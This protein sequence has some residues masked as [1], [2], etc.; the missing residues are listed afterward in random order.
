M[1]ASWRSSSLALLLVACVPTR[2][3]T[4]H[5]LGV[6]DPSEQVPPELYRIKITGKAQ[7]MSKVKYGSGW[8]PARQADLLVQDIRPD[9]QGKFTISGQ[10][11]DAVSMAVRRRFFEI[12][13]FAVA[14]E[15]EDGRFVVVM[16]S[17]PDYFFKKI[18]L[19]T[20]FGKDD[21][22]EASS[23]AALIGKVQQKR[24]A[25]GQ[26]ALATRKELEG[27]NSADTQA[28]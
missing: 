22:A 27:T 19:L 8:V 2:V 10:N 5:F 7:W 11:S 17:D 24:I 20:R 9:E 21:S 28:K 6:F 14:T 15:P 13:P 26:D 1:L 18:G 16:S 12:G 23:R 4:E 3:H 25:V